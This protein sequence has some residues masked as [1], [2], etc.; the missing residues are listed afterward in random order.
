MISVLCSF[1]GRK[2][3]SIPTVL[4]G[5]IGG[6]EARCWLWP[7]RGSSTPREGPGSKKQSSQAGLANQH[8]QPVL[9]R[10]ATVGPGEGG[11]RRSPL[12][13][14]R[15]GAA[16]WA[17]GGLRSVSRMVAHLQHPFP[18]H[19][20]Y[21]HRVPG[22]PPSG[23]CLAAT[24]TLQSLVAET[25]YSCSGDRLPF[26]K[27]SLPY[28]H[29]QPVA[30]EEAELVPRVIRARPTKTQPCLPASL[31]FAHHV[32]M[33]GSQGPPSPGGV[34]GGSRA[35]PSWGLGGQ[36]ILGGEGGW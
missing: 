1:L 25:N 8:S 23:P 7:L 19:S 31:L 28:P 2:W 4:M 35:S 34:P 3:T 11:L 29:H 21:F 10:R 6:L 27:S 15:A 30:T 22:T 12:W 20:W 5:M 17:G 32:W 24:G 33:L 26:P 16:A 9:A 14:P 36:Q 18:V 13:F